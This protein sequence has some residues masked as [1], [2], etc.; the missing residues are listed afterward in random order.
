MDTPFTT[1]A[2]REVL[3]EHLY[4]ELTK[5]AYAPEERRLWAD[6][7][8]RL[9]DG[10]IK[11]EITCHLA[12]V[13]LG[14][15]ASTLSDR[16]VIAEEGGGTVPIRIHQLNEEF[17]DE[18]NEPEAP[19]GEESGGGTPSDDTEAPQSK[20]PFA[21]DADLRMG[22]EPDEVRP[23][24]SASKGSIF[25]A[26]QA[27]PPADSTKEREPTPR[28]IRPRVLLGTAAGAYGKPHE[29]WL[30]PNLP[31][32]NLPNPHISITGETGSGKTQAIKAIVS[33]PGAQGLPAL[34]LDFKDDYSDETFIGAEDFRLYDAS[35][36]SL[37][38]NPLTPAVDKRQDFV[39]PSQ[40]IYQVSNIIKRIYKLGDQQA[41]RLR[42]AIK[43]AYDISGISL[44]PGLLAA[45]TTFP[46][47]DNVRE[48]LLEDKAN[49]PL[50]G[51]LSPIFDLGLFRTDEAR[52]TL[53]DFLHASSVIRLGQLPSDEVKT[54]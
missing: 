17:I 29:V 19:S 50:L 20:A 9:L 7:L 43:H 42:E 35:F 25:V 44:R 38:F 18:L 45:G 52:S 13:R 6:R 31:D 26:K 41:F 5:D 40:H 53:D 12:D 22:P 30:D 1:P 48:E 47:F 21:D 14:A 28:A 33:E 4:R 32:Q 23:T 39:N 37:P 24:P 49:E 3:R 2:R 54:P 27:V 36:E 34:I 46:P 8:R 15:H 11:I 10:K 51:R 16:S